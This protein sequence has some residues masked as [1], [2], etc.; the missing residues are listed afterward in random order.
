[1]SHATPGPTPAQAAWT[2][3]GYGLCLIPDYHARF[4]REA[5]H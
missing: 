3:L 2:R 1:M 5:A 4:L